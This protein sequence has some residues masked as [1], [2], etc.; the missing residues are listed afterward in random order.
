MYLTSCSAVNSDHL[1]VL[2]DTVCRSSFHLPPDRPDLRRTAWTNFQNHPEDQ[3]PFNPELHDGMAIDTCVENFSSTVPKALA[4]SNGR[5]R[6]DP[7]TQC[8]QEWS[9]RCNT[10]ILRSRR[11]ITVK[12]G[13]TCDES[14]Y[15]VS[16]LI[17]PAAIVLSNPEKA[18]ALSDRLE[19]QFH[20]WPFLRSPKLLKWLKW[21]WGITS[22]PL[23]G[24]P[25]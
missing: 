4:A 22:W 21:R 2:I 10:R 1:P 23:Q 24:N 8:V 12:N 14:S 15:S 16:L 3:I 7:P 17:T 19:T 9:V 20:R 18:E 25:S 13:Q 11:L 6:D 5:P